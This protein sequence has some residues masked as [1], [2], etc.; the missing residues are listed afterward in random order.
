MRSTKF[1]PEK[2][3]EI[4]VFY[5]TVLWKSPLLRRSVFLL[6]LSNKILIRLTVKKSSADK[7]QMKNTEGIYFR[8]IKRTLTNGSISVHTFATIF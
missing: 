1:P 5:V 8:N 3:C 6:L 7:V 2:I 4:L